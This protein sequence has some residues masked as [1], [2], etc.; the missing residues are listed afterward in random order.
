MRKSIWWVVG[1]LILASAAV[2]LYS[3][4]ASHNAPHAPPIQAKAPKPAPPA[5]AVQNPVP[6]P[7]ISQTQSLPSLADSDSPVRNALNML[8]GEAATTHL[9]KPDMI[10]RHMVVTIDNLSRKRAALELRPVRPAPGQFMVKGDDQHAVIDPANYQRYTPYV[11]ALQAMDVKQLVQVYF[12]FYPLFQQAYQNLGYP[13][14]YFNDR[15]VETIDNLL[16]TPDVSG[17]IALVRPNVM[18]QFADPML[19]NLSAGQKMLVRMGPQN[20]AAV[21]VKLKELRAAIADRS[22]GG[23]SGRTRDSAGG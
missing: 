8:I 19:E 18:Y 15:L 13:N 22:R 7:S 5:P 21:K 9:V 11:Q 14:G 10:V 17:D 16:E 12:H 6:A 4:R 2:L 23:D 3:W 20:E 1:V